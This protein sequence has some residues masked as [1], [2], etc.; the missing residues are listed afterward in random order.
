MTYSNSDTALDELLGAVDDAVLARLDGAADLDAGRAAIFASCTAGIPLRLSEPQLHFDADVVEE[1]RGLY[2]PALGSGAFLTRAFAEQNEQVL[3]IVGVLQEAVWQIGRLREW[4]RKNDFSTRV[5]ISLA[6]PHT[7]L[8]RL[9]TTLTN[10]E[11]EL[12]D[13][14][15]M[16]TMVARALRKTGTQVTAHCEHLDL[17]SSQ[18]HA[19]AAIM[20]DELNRARSLVVRLFAGDDHGSRVPAPV[21]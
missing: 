3:E 1:A 16:L 15:L 10:R 11:L 6:A 14:L 17:D 7:E 20:S 12:R 2:D 4:L 5:Q 18:Y 9:A 8:Y 21:Q 13:A 19:R